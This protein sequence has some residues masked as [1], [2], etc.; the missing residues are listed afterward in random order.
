MWVTFKSYVSEM[1]SFKLYKLV[2]M[3]V[4]RDL[5]KHSLEIKVNLAPTD[6][7][8]LTPPNLRLLLEM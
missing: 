3:H 2:L 6:K 4:N 7:I 5:D 1:F 8:S